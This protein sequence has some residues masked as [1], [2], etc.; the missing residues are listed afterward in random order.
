[1]TRIVRGTITLAALLLAAVASAAEETPLVEIELLSTN[2]SRPGDDL[3][4]LAYEASSPDTARMPWTIAVRGAPYAFVLRFNSPRLSRD[5]YR[6]GG[7][8]PKEVV[9]TREW[10]QSVQC[11][12]EVAG[13][14]EVPFSWWEHFMSHGDLE[15]S[16]TFFSTPRGGRSTLS[17]SP[18]STWP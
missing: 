6:P 12:I 16:Y 18:D 15:P 5:V 1:M 14:G 10:L 13:G 7:P 17:H 11:R 3:L 9:F 4:F 2:D 8:N